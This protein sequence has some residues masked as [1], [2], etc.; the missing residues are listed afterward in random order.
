MLST[1][2]LFKALSDETRLRILNLL[3]ERELC[4]CD[5]MSVLGISQS[6]AS[7]HLI[8]LKRVGLTNDR[9]EAQ[10]MYYSLVP[11]KEAL[12]IEELVV[13]R[14]RKDERCFEDL[15][16]LDDWLKEKERKCAQCAS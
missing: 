8:A 4:V 5:V 2:E 9:R 13:N 1:V 15:K 11:G 12:F 16:L 3:Y 14:L 7:R 10:W 6:R